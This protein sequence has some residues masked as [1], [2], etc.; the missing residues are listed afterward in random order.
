MPIR[1]LPFAA[2]LGANAI[3]LIGTQLTF[4]AVPW[5]VLQT[6]GSAAKTGLTGAAGALATVLAAF[7]GSIVVDRLGF[8]RTSI[9]TD[10]M[11]GLTVAMIP[12]LSHT[13]GLAFWQLLLLVFLRAL[14][15]T[16][17][18]TARQ[19]LLPDLITLAGI[20][21]ERGNA[22]YQTVQYFAQLLGPVLA[23]VLI[24]LLGT[25]NVLWLDATSF[26]VSA[27]IVSAAVPTSHPTRPRHGESAGMTSWWTDLR[28]GVRFLRDDRV[29]YAMAITS[30][31]ANFLIAALFAVI[32]PVYAKTRFGRALDLGLLFAGFGAG[33]L[34][35]TLLYGVIAARVPRRATLITGFVIASIPLWVLAILPSLVVA[36]GVMVLF[37]FGIG[38]LNV[39]GATVTQERVPLPFRG[40]VFGTLFAISGATTPL[41]VLLSGYL[42]EGIGLRTILLGEAA[43]FV[44][45]TGWIAGIRAFRTMEPSAARVE[46]R[47]SV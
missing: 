13:V 2:L 34:V 21:L 11:S 5:F 24:A 9:L 14:L 19:S 17:G 4:V 31:V 41:A 47:H 37:G 35:A 44:S 30:T 40:R 28:E 25:R 45:L 3:S 43:C 16:P 36:I 23:G 38:P 33:S 7:F 6:T 29:V 10:L 27:G 8:K 42:I 26:L 46:E 20:G 1:R 12:V 15:N 18:A 32:L 22:A 39:L